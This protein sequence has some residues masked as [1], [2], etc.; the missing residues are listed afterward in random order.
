VQNDRC[1]I[2]ANLMD[3]GMVLVDFVLYILEKIM[4]F[5]IYIF[6]KTKDE[7]ENYTMRKYRKTK[8]PRFN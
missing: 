8:E 2:A 5:E 4:I 6:H 7:N 1:L 3:F